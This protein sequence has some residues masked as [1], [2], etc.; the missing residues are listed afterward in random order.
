M[1]GR[2]GVP[3]TG[4]G[5]VALNV[6]ATESAGGGYVTVWPCGAPR[7]GTSTLNLE[8][9]GHTVANLAIVGVGGAGTVCLFTSTGTHLIA[10]V[11]GWSATGSG[12]STVQPSRLLETRPAAGQVAWAGTKPAANQLVQVPVAGRGGVPAN[13]AGAV[14]VNVTAT[15]AAGGGFVTVWPCGSPRPAT[16]TLNLE[17]AGHTVANLAVV[18]IG[19]EGRICLT[20]S[21]GVHLIADV[22]AW[23][24]TGSGLATVQ[25][26]RL[27]ETRAAAGNLG[28]AGAKPEAGQVVQ[29]QVTGRG[30]IPA[31]G[32]GTVALNITATEAAGAGYV[33]VWPCGVAPPGTST[34]NLEQ[35]GSTVAN[36]AVV[37]LGTGGTVCL[38]ASAGTHLMADVTAWAAA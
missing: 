16:S 24:P 2:G 7:P 35:A 5:A 38:W 32:A 9:P 25:P 19:I 10:D 36:L 23:S 26:A 29:L 33:T 20:S 13:G 8:R 21:T 11:T 27:L 4:A 1:A 18:G 15:E 22:T 17:R 6:T 3:A 12:L 34:L 30:G 31:S 28:Y 37:G 14:V